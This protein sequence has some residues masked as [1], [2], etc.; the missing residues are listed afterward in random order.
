MSTI[1]IIDIIGD[2]CEVWL[3]EDKT[4]VTEFEEYAS[5][6]ATIL[7]Y[8][9]SN[10]SNHLNENEIATVSVQGN[11]INAIYTGYAL[12]PKKD[13]IFKNPDPELG[14]FLVKTDTYAV[15]PGSTTTTAFS[16]PLCFLPDT[17]I[18][19]A[20]NQHKPVGDLVVGDLVATPEGAQAVKFVGK[21]TRNIFDLRQSGRM[22]IRIEAGA[23]GELG[24]DAPIHCTPSHAFHLKGCLVEA[25]AMVNGT[26]IQQLNDWDELLLTYIS[27]ELEDHQLIWANGLLAET[28]YAN[29]RNDGFT[30]QLWDNYD[31]YLELYGESNAMVELSLPRIPFARLLPGKL[32]L[33]LQCNEAIQSLQLV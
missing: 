32:R 16:P 22:P 2:Y 30:R 15:T 23:L 19:L 9:D 8:N 13:P 29:W 4:L 21:S 6:S 27:I 1:D 17:L 7:S 18:K 31:H 26:T 33:M 25:Q 20:D 3:S 11:I 5:V 24:P 14:Y 12:G 10:S 28:Y